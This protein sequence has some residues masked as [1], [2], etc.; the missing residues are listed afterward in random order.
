VLKGSTRTLD[1][2]Q[3]IELELSF[4]PLSDGQA[5]APTLIEWLRDQGFGVGGFD[6]ETLI[7]RSGELLEADVVFV[8]VPSVVA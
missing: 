4:V 7:D 3:A 5:L 6:R 8:R 2:C 1:A